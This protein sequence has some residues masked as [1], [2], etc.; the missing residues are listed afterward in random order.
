[1]ILDEETLK[2]RTLFNGRALVETTPGTNEAWFTTARA[3]LQ[4][5]HGILG[6]DGGAALTN[7]RVLMLPLE[8]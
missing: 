2:G 5:A 7:V 3:F 6:V 4:Q 1:V 8:G